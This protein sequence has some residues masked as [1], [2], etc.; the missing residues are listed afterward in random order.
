[1]VKQTM[2][3]EYG[4]LNSRSV[5]QMLSADGGVSVFQKSFS[6]IFSINNSFQ[7]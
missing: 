7:G 5:D 1:M 2:Q 3:M 6:F 4:M